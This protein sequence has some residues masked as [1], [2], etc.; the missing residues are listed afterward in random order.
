MAV[1]ASGMPVLN[2]IG[3][4]K[5]TAPQLD[6]SNGNMK[7]ALYLNTMT[8]NFSDTLANS[9]YNVAQYATTYECA[10]SGNYAQGG[11]AVAGNALAEGVAGTINADAN[12]QAW[13]SSTIAN[14]RCAVIYDNV[15]SPKA[16]WVLVNFGADYS[17]SNGTFTVQWSTSPSA[18]WTWDCTP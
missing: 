7:C 14:A 12:D 11:Q 1:T 6:W 5:L 2:L 17:T 10:N 9:A 3:K 4:L 8:P 18:V 15:L 16:V 13:S